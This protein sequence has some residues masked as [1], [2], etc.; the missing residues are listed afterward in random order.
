M[1]DVQRMHY[2]RKELGE[3]VAFYNGSNPLALAAF[4]AGANGYSVQLPSKSYP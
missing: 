2:L 4:S 3:E 1:G